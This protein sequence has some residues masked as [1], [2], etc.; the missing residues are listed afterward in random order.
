MDETQNT[1]GLLQ[2]LENYINCRELSRAVKKHFILD[3][4]ISASMHEGKSE[5]FGPLKSYVC[6]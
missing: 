5:I 3:E 4:N 2:T 6:I 1:T